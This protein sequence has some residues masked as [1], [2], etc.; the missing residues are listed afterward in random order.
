LNKPSTKIQTLKAIFQGENN[1]E[2]N[3]RE[4]YMQDP[5][6]QHHF[7]EFCKR[8]KVRGI[9]L[10]E[11]L[12]IWKQSQIYVLAR[13]LCMKIMQEQHDVPMSGHYGEQTT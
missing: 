1:L 3:I 4:A 8:K 12:I 10:K 5:L 6:I 11:G 13:K 9:T 2:N 7:K